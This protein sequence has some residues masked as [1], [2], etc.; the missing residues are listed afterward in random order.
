MKKGKG[1]F[2]ELMLVISWN[3]DNEFCCTKIYIC[4]DILILNFKLLHDDLH[5]LKF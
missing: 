1:Y 3:Y 2:V 4:E 5:L